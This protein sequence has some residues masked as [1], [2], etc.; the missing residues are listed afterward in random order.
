[1][2]RL[3]TALIGAYDVGFTIVSITPSLVA[4]FLPI[5][6][7]SGIVGRLLREL[8]ASIVGGLIVNQAPNFASIASGCGFARS[9]ASRE[10]NRTDF[11]PPPCRGRNMSESISADECELRLRADASCD[12]GALKP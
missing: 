3:Q 1:M 12:E 8:R 5:L 10:L 7:R 6:L 4:A 9:G 11:G 2:S